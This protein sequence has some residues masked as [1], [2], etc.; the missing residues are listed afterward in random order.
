MG[1][2]APVVAKVLW[3]V[4]HP[5]VLHEL[6]S[7][8]LPRGALYDCLLLLVKTQVGLGKDSIHLLIPLCPFLVFHLHAGCRMREA[9]ACRRM[10]LL[11][12]RPTKVT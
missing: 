5:L 7:K 8:V 6:L 4:S 1:A 9:G 10:Q 3:N 11:R 12:G 2:G